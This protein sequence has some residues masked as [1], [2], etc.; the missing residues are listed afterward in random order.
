[1]GFLKSLAT[2][3]NQAVEYADK[4]YSESKALEAEAWGMS[5]RKL[6]DAANLSHGFKRAVYLAV[7]Q[8]RDDIDVDKETHRCRVRKITF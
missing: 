1:M 4:K 7:A 8:K 6:C 5:A 3:A 2:I